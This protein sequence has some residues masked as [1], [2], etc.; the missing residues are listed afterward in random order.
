LIT[1]NDT[2]QRNIELQLDC[3]VIGEHLLSDYLAHEKLKT[4]TPIG[5]K[6]RP[7]IPGWFCLVKS[8]NHSIC[9]QQLI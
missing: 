5:F 8:R 7:I 1:V 2:Q 6:D 4:I 3:S 9:R